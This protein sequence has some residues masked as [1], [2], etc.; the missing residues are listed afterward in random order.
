MRTVFTLGTTEPTGTGTLGHLLSRAPDDSV[1]PAG[2]GPAV[3]DREAQSGARIMGGWID[4][5]CDQL[6]Q[7]PAPPLILH[8]SAAGAAVLGPHPSELE[9]PVPPPQSP[10]LQRAGLVTQYFEYHPEIRP[11]WILIRMPVGGWSARLRHRAPPSAS[12]TIGPTAS[13]WA[14]M[15]LAAEEAAVRIPAEC[16]PLWNDYLD[17]AREVA[18]E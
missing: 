5:P 17:V 3:A 16:R 8:R 11:V 10:W 14:G 18:A 13:Q 2:L 4:D 6:P 15:L 7:P 12:P 9:R 1:R